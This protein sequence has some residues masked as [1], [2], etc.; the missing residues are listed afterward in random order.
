LKTPGELYLRLTAID[1]HG[2]SYPVTTRSAGGKAK[3][4]K[5]RNEVAIGGGAA[6]GAL[7]GGIAGGGKGLGIGALAGAGAGTAGAYATGKKDIEYP[8]ETPL[9]FHLEHAVNVP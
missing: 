3:S 5:K 9:T 2:K 6:A 4:H 1:I 7:I 8:V